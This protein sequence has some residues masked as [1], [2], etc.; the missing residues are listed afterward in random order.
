MALIHRDP[1]T[2]S[3]LPA[4]GLEPFGLM[5]NL[6]RWDP[7]RD[8]PFSLD[9]KEGFLPSFDILETPEAYVFEADLPGIKES[10]LDI[11]LTGNRLTIA[12]H[13]ESRSR[14]EG[15]NAFSQE[16]SFG[17]FTR[18]FTLPEGVDSGQVSACL[19][20]GVLSLRIPKMPEVQPRKISLTQAGQ[21]EIKG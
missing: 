2:L 20:D 11:H 3:P 8:Q 6:L 19:Q 10:D 21:A 4:P 16:R 12:G 9:L 18:S 15:E 7:F 13:R 17:S 1:R 14:Q 5:R